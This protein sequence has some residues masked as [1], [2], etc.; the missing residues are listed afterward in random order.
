MEPTV[1]A[2]AQRTPRADEAVVVASG[3]TRVYG[4]NEPTV[5]ALAAR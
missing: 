5:F 2:D 1:S 3:L 4:E